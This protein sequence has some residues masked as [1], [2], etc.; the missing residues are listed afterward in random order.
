MCNV[1][2]DI[3]KRSKNI[4]DFIKI[5]MPGFMSV[6][7][8]C[9]LDILLDIYCKCIGCHDCIKNAFYKSFCQMLRVRVNEIPESL[10]SISVLQ[11]QISEVGNQGFSQ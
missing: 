3:V 7:F 2:T 5:C 8:R 10:S 6:L 9:P 11:N 4:E 1:I